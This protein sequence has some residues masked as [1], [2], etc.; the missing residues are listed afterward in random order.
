MRPTPFPDAAIPLKLD[1]GTAADMMT[2]NPV[3]VRGDATITEIIALLVDKGFGA[4]PVIDDAGR[5]I[6][7]VSRSDILAHERNAR[8]HSPAP[9]ADAARVRDIM[10]PIVFS[11]APDMPGNKVIQEMAALKVHRLFVVD[12]AGNLVGVITALDILSRLR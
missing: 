1:A 7:V 6:G 3:S 10:T 2:P 5:P 12:G 9:G 4:A 11:V 8:I